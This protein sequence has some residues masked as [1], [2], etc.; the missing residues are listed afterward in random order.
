[1]RDLSPSQRLLQP[2]PR[3]AR[4]AQ[5]QLPTF[6]DLLR[7]SSPTNTTRPTPTKGRVTPV[8]PNLRTANRMREKMGDVARSGDGAPKVMAKASQ[9]AVAGRG[10][11]TRLRWT[12]TSSSATST[13]SGESDVVWVVP[14]VRGKTF[15]KDEVEVRMGTRN[16]ANLRRQVKADLAPLFDD[17][18]TAELDV[19]VGGVVLTPETLLSSLP[20]GAGSVGDPFV[21][22]AMEK[23]QEVLGEVGMEGGEREGNTTTESKGEREAVEGG[24]DASGTSEEEVVGSGQVEEIKGREE[25]SVELEGDDKEVAHSVEIDGEGEETRASGRGNDVVEVV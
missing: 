7:N 18:S 23:G 5:H 22:R 20:K 17:W 1:M 3:Q 10:E 6:R 16:I 13:L 25:E 21:V 11:K 24:G 14:D 2:S 9:E 19:M 12:S 8:G 4:A 15:R